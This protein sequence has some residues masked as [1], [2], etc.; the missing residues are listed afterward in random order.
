MSSEPESGTQI[1]LQ[2]IRSQDLTNLQP[3]QFL[4]GSFGD[5]LL[6]NITKVGEYFD[7]VQMFTTVRT[8]PNNTGL[9]ALL[10]T[11]MDGNIITEHTIETGG[12]NL[13]V[14]DSEMINST[15][16]LV[17]DNDGPYLWNIYDDTIV[18]YDFDGHHE[19]EYNY[20]NGNMFTLKTVTLFHNSK[21]YIYDQIVEFN[22]AGDI[23]WV[24]DTR[25]WIDPLVGGFGGSVDYTHGNV[26]YYDAWDDTLLFNARN[27]N[28]FYKINH[29]SGEMIWGVGDLGNFTMFNAE[30]VEVESLF[31]RPHGLEPVGNNT[32]I[33]LQNEYEGIV[34]N[35]EVS[36]SRILEIQIDEEKMEARYFWDWVPP[37][38]YYIPFWGDA[39][40]LPNGNRVGTF[41]TTFKQGIAMGA[42]LPEINGNEIVYEMNFPHNYIEQFNQGMYRTER[43]SFSP[44]IFGAEFINFLGNTEATLNWDTHYNFESKNPFTGFYEIY[45][46]GNLVESGEH[47][48]AKYWLS[49]PIS[50][51]FGILPYGEYNVSLIVYDEGGH[52]SKFDTQLISA[53]FII[54]QEGELEFEFGLD[55]SFVI[56]GQTNSPLEVEIS[57]DDLLISNFT[58]SG[59]QFSVNLSTFDPGDYELRIEFYNYSESVYLILEEVL[60]HPQEAPIFTSIPERTEFQIGQIVIFDWNI[61]DNSPKEFEIYVDDN[62]I[63]SSDWNDRMESI[64]M[65]TGGLGLGFHN[66]TVLIRDQ[67]DLIASNTYIFEIIASVVPLIL[68]DLEALEFEWKS[69]V[70]LSWTVS[71]ASDW[72]IFRNGFTL[73][74]GE[75][76][77][78]IVSLSVLWNADDWFIGTFQLELHL[79]NVE[80][81]SSSV[82]NY[83]INIII[84]FSDLYVDSHISNT[85]NSL[86]FFDGSNVYGA[87]DG[88]TAT[89]QGEYYTGGFITLDMG[90]SEEILNVEGDDFTV[91]ADI[92]IYAVYAGNDLANLRENHREGNYLAEGSGI[93]SFDL[94]V[95]GLESA[96]YIQIELRTGLEIKLDAIVAKEVNNHIVDNAIPEIGSPNDINVDLSIENVNIIWSA[97]DLL[98]YRYSIQIDNILIKEQSWDGTAVLYEFNIIEIGEFVITITFSDLFSNVASD[99]V[100]IKVVNL[101]TEDPTISESLSNTDTVSNSQ[102]SSQPP[103]QPSSTASQNSTV[104]TFVVLIAIVVVL[105]GIRISKARKL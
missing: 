28:T 96:R 78:N 23:I 83:E 37:E 16:A 1:E 20:R 87:P 71:G 13:H 72:T 27:L 74:S 103:N 99:S 55:R 63:T 7:S 90:E 9:T 52:S 24:F 75:V 12:S 76:I 47:A 22:E 80:Y 51:N 36:L 31:I 53:D 25:D 8:Y 81:S 26:I 38:G 91:Y 98:P 104:P 69:D 64:R 92:N 86:F 70:T 4:F 17:S 19:Y 44:I 45:L 97:Y 43:I 10:F 100:L 5:N 95:L 89:L 66:I 84:Q 54:E 3:N 94:S 73:S 82:F 60:I 33:M 48:F 62:L 85:Q 58:W 15:T 41:G 2:P 59:E 34:D 102:P 88:N 49:T 105:Q 50:H 65:S 42:R 46:D 61:F 11:D 32:Y 93:S 101:T 18:R 40:R 6:A 77:N 68:D 21:N 56:L 79:F 57:V 35:R 30:G 67:L 14:M 29:T 39:D